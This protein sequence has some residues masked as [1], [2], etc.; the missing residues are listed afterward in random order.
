MNNLFTIDLRTVR[1][2]A[3][4]MMAALLVVAGLPFFQNSSVSAAQFANRSIQMSDSSPSGSSI[5]SGVGSGLG[6]KYRVTFTPSVAAQSLVIDFCSNTP[7]IGDSTGCT[8]PIGMFSATSYNGISGQ[9]NAANGWALAATNTAGGQIKIANTGA[10]N[11]MQAG[12]QQVFDLVGVTNPSSLTDAASVTFSV[13]SFYAR[14][15]SYDNTTYG[16]Y[17]SPTSLGTV[18]AGNIYVDYGGIALATTN[19]IQITARVQESLQFCVTTADPVSST[20]H[21]CSDTSVLANPPIITIG[22]GTPTPVL[23]SSAV[24]QA[25]V[26]SQLTTNAT[27][28]AV[29]NLHNANTC[30]GLTANGGTTCDIA[31]IN[32]G[33]NAGPSDM[34]PNSPQG[35][36]G[37]FV[38]NGMASDATSVNV[39]NELASPVY[40]DGIHTTIPASVPGPLNQLYYGMDTT[41]N[42]A[43]SSL[44]PASPTPTLRSGRTNGLT[45]PSGIGGAFGSTVAYTSTP[46]YRV[47]NTYVFAATAALTTPAG[48]YTAN[49]SLIASGTF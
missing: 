36:I 8:I 23:E 2:I 45:N 38:S 10:S 44:L 29:I 49:M 18:A 26:F 35:I 40:N 15:Y 20:T 4:T 5:T 25:K 7:I 28:G 33:S 3:C 12:V 41:S 27:H 22:H 21:D 43:V 42:D 1:R 32:N 11:P 14:M 6:V 17:T 24:D 37:V 19:V 31:A 30:G 9:I 48:I 34:N 47:D 39:A 16:G 13:N 46:V